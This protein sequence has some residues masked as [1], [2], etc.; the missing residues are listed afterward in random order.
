MLFGKGVNQSRGQEAERLACTFLQSHNVTILERNYHCRQG[1][2]DIIGREQNTIVFV[3]VRYR[4]H[5]QFGSGAESVT[6]NKQKK[7]L[8]TAQTYIARRLKRELPC[9]FDVLEAHS[10]DDGSLQFNWLKNAFQE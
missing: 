1:E 3:E 7:L 2:I 6:R 4:R 9:R 10:K 5:S 8:T